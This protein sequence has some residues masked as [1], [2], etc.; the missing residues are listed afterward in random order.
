MN[1]ATAG[2]ALTLAIDIG[3]TGL[4]ASVLDQ[5]GAMRAPRVHLPTPHPAPPAILLDALAELI[6]KLPPF[7]R[8]SAGFPGAVRSGVVLTAP[9]LGN[10]E[11]A[12][13]PL[14]Q[15]LTERFGRPARVENDAAVQGFGVISGHGMEM[16]LTL[17]TGAGMAIFLDGRMAPHLELSQH[18]VHND[19]TYDA[20]L[21]KA[22]LDKIGPRHW[23]KRVRKAIAILER[24]VLFDTLYIGGGHAARLAGN[25]PANVKI[26]ANEAG[27]TGGIALWRGPGAISSPAIP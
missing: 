23:N 26:V 7:D 15:K 9:N 16:I 18:P 6:R 8:I 14:Q 5:D 11:W 25:F 19:L 13:F 21:G 22:A 10:K 24:V 4:K 1:R 20:Y 2:K 12:R 17:G 27:I 3:G